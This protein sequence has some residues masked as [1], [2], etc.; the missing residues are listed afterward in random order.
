LLF[1]Y[2]F[3]YLFIHFISQSMPLTPLL[4]VPLSHSISPNPLPFS[5]EKA[6]PP[7]KYQLT[8]GHQVSSGLTTYCSTEARQGNP[9]RRKKSKDRQQSS[10]LSHLLLHLLGDPHEDQATYQLTMKRGLGPVHTCSLIG[11]PVSVSSHGP[12]VVGSVGLL[13][14]F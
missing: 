4:P 1:I 8:L 14:V 7:P 5:L 3:I 13:V 6:S 9:A 10:S 2:L 11:V 12:R